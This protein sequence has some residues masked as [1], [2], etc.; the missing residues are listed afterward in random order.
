MTPPPK[1]NDVK[2]QIAELVE[3]EAILSCLQGSLAIIEAPEWMAGV[4][5]LLA[6][7][8]GYHI[9]WWP[10]EN[11]EFIALMNAHAMSNGYQ[12]APTDLID[13][14]TPTESSSDA[15][16]DDDD[17][18]PR[19][20]ADD[21]P[22]DPLD[23]PR[24]ELPDVEIPD[25]VEGIKDEFTTTS[26]LTASPSDNGSHN[27]WD[28]IVQVGDLRGVGTDQDDNEIIQPLYCTECE[29]GYWRTF[30]AVP[31]V[32]KDDHQWAICSE[33]RR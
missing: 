8:D 32:D 13:P 12:P 25:T 10:P 9:P 18:T 21:S 11:T 20:Q 26:Q 15:Q 5:W 17:L 27:C 23:A 4:Q 28:H 16:Q 7:D 30:V 14:A 19:E 29:T 2:D 1:P 31:L 22:D 3:E 6:D 33:S 24:T